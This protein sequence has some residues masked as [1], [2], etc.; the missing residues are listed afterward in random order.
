MVSAARRNSNSL[1]KSAQ[2]PLSILSLHIIVWRV[3]VQVLNIDSVRQ[4][5]LSKTN[6]GPYKVHL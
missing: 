5:L 6:G 1:C 4:V 2:K 3:Q